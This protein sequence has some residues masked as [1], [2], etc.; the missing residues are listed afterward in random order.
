MKDIR[1]EIVTDE[2]AFHPIDCRI[3]DMVAQMSFIELVALHTQAA[4]V[5]EEYRHRAVN[6][7]LERGRECVLREAE[8]EIDAEFEARLIDGITY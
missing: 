3:G 7:L 8:F 5:I 4:E 1:I 6:A 2:E